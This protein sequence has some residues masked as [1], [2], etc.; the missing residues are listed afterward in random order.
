MSNAET[1]NKQGQKMNARYKGFCRAC[2]STISAGAKITKDRGRWVHD[3]CAIE[4]DA[5]ANA[6][7]HNVKAYGRAFAEG[8]SMND[9]AL[10][11]NDW[12]RD[13]GRK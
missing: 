9:G 12:A 3:G 2:N 1:T 10:A 13:G 7:S 6:Y 5:N 4:R 11:V 8:Y